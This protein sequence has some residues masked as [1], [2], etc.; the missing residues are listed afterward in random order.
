MRFHSGRSRAINCLFVVIVFVI[1]RQVPFSFLSFLMNISVF[2]IL[3]LALKKVEL[4]LSDFYLITLLLIFPL[5]VSLIYSIIFTDN[6]I[7][8]SLRFYLILIA[9]G[10]AY[11][12]CV[13]ERALKWMLIL[14]VIQSLFIL[15]F[16]AYLVVFQTQESYLPIRFFIQERG[17]G[18]VYTYNGIFYRIQLK[19]NSLLV[20]AFIMNMELKLLK[21]RKLSSFMLFLGIIIAGNFAFLISLGLYFVYR[22]FNLKN[23]KSSSLYLGRWLFIILGL[24]VIF[25]YVYEFIQSTLESK[26]DESLGTRWDQIYHLTRDMAETPFTLF[27]GKGLGNTL[28]VVSPFRDYTDNI[29]F[30]VQSVYFLNQLGVLFTCIFFVYNGLVVI[31]RWRQSEAFTFVVIL[32]SIYLVYSVTNPYVLDTNQFVVII[33]LNSIIKNYK[34]LT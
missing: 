10:L 4:D 12:V 7:L 6:S 19:G 30:E 27:F 25:P 14:C 17:W 9:V 8:N 5:T 28:S 34:E 32:Y 33:V 20:V 22:S 16:S 11:F 26:S 29:Y 3:Y 23:V 21:Y 24:C 15:F 18:D 13:D 31:K 1:T 2:G